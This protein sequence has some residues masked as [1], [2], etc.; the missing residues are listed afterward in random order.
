MGHLRPRVIVPSRSFANG[1]W[2]TRATAGATRASR[3][4][5]LRRYMLV[6]HLA[7]RCR[8]ARS[9]PAAL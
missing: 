2:L 8:K 6:T 4:P 1:K 3:S 5:S 7:E 9:M